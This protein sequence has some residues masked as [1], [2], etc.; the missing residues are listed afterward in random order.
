MTFSK[1][2]KYLLVIAAVLVAAVAFK[3]LYPVAREMFS[4][5]NGNYLKQR[6]VTLSTTLQKKKQLENELLFL[7]KKLD[8]LENRLVAGDT[9]ALAAVNIQNLIYELGK[10]NQVE[11]D[12][13]L[14]MKSTKYDDERLAMYSSLGIQV[15]MKVTI[16]QLQGIFHG[17]MSSSI[18]LRI[19]DLQVQRM[20]D[21]EN[22]LLN[23]T[24]TVMAPM[25]GG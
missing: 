1:R 17:I 22:A 10:Q 19:T 8:R 24:F 2:Q 16:G 14:V 9:A 7:E 15:R 13:L 11:I 3:Q 21:K 4:D 20:R 6:I 18:I 12:S 23:V 25:L 5:E